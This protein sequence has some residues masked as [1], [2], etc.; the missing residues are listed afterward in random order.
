MGQYVSSA[1]AEANL[2]MWHKDFK[3][4]DVATAN[5]AIE[6]ERVLVVGL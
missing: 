5:E 4:V 1:F 6:W 3:F 2:W